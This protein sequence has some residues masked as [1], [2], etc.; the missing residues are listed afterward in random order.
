VL[1]CA[2]TAVQ[3]TQTQGEAELA[4]DVK[5]RAMAGSGSVDNAGTEQPDR[6]MLQALDGPDAMVCNAYYST[7]VHAAIGMIHT[8]CAGFCCC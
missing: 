5:M 6:D 4:S 7:A 1:V 8:Q 3:Y 2:C